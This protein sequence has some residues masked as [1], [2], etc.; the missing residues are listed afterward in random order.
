MKTFPVTCN[1][2]LLNAKGFGAFCPREQRETLNLIAERIHHCFK[3]FYSFPQVIVF[4]WRAPA[5]LSP[6]APQ[7]RNSA[8]HKECFIFR[9]I[10]TA[11]IHTLS[12]LP[13]LLPL[14]LQSRCELFF[15]SLRFLFGSMLLPRD[16]CHEPFC[17]QPRSACPHPKN[18]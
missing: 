17:L 14:V 18:S 12:F 3:F 11:E 9:F 10:Y 8:G 16:F 6:V 4:L 15:L 2:W 7:I 1:E 5:Q 13:P